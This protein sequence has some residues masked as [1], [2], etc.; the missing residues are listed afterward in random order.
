MGKK[1]L[2]YFQEAERAAGIVGAMKLAGLTT[3]TTVYAGSVEDT[4]ELVARFEK[5]LA[6]IKADAAPGEHRTLKPGGDADM[7]RKH[8]K[9]FLDVMSQR[10]LT[11]GK[12]TETVRRVDEAAVDA[13]GVERV[14]VWFLDDARTKITC[15]DLFERTSRKHS[16]GVELFRKDFP[17]Y[18]T[19]LESERTIAAHDAHT[20]PRT[21]CFSSV[22]LK[23]LG[24]G[25]MLDVPIWAS[26]KMI[27]VVC[28]EHIGNQRVW[29]SDDEH[30]AYLMASFVSLAVERAA[31]AR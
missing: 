10:S 22:Y 19:S 26:G 29:S 28:H 4:P 31:P 7:L 5:A 12:V 16:S 3:V 9:V 6:K 2:S 24:I 21:S 14:S 30:F 18:F 11:L 25:A 17:S 15:M 20:D 13:L 1:L 27:G 23:P 8:I